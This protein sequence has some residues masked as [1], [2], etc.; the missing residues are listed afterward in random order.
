MLKIYDGGTDLVDGF[1]E[2]IEIMT[3][4]TLNMR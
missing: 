3:W 4:L 2:V 1:P